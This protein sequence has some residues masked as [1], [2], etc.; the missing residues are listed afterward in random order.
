MSE[1]NESMLWWNFKLYEE[2]NELANK[3]FGIDE[4]ISVD[5]IMEIYKS[6]K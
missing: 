5:Q 6:E 2:R 3:Y 4:P 1:V